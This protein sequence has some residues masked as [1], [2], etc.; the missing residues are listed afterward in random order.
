MMDEDRERDETLIGE[1]RAF[2]AD[3]DPVP[4]LVI[5]AAK[6]ALGWRS[7]D[8][9]LAELLRDS[10][11]DEE[12]LAL[13][14]SAA[15]ATR[16]LTFS[17][18]GLTIDVE[19]HADDATRTLLGQLSPPRVATIEIQTVAE[20]LVSVATDHLGRFRASLP[21]GRIVR[22]RVVDPD[23]PSGSAVQTSWI[24]V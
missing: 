1:L 21:A 5:E 14:R 11:L 3:V 22:M 13:A 4:P 7:L 20:P 8:A 23:R 19:I 24:S 15:A 9:D 12:S 16:S 17:A 10:A 2:F 18:S 6:A